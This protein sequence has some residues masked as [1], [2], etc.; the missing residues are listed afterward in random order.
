MCVCVYLFAKCVALECMSIKSCIGNS[1]DRTPSLPGRSS[2][3]FQPAASWNFTHLSK[4][5][6][7]P[8][9]YSAVLRIPQPLSAFYLVNKLKLAAK[10]W[11]YAAGVYHELALCPAAAKSCYKNDLKCCYVHI[12]HFAMST[13]IFN[14]AAFYGPL[15]DATRG[16]QVLLTAF[17]GHSLPLL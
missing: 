2:M 1:A 6:A 15:V 5:S 3:R 7:S 12:V 10:F 16:P 4:L 9:A 17:N 8:A 11:L 14:S 13:K